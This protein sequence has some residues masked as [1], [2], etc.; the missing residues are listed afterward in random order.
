M[1]AVA[2]AERVLTSMRAAGV[3]PNDRTYPEL[4]RLLAT[5]GRVRDAEAYLVRARLRALRAARFGVRRRAG[6][7]SAS[8][9]PVG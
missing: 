5:R 4:I 9:R 7:L 1:G 8:Y 6:S 3:R 2:E